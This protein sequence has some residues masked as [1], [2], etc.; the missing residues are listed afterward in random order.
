MKTGLTLTEVDERIAAVRENLEELVEQSTADSSAGNDD[1]NAGRIS[2]TGAG[3]RKTARTERNLAAGIDPGFDQRPLGFARQSRPIF[4]RRQTL[5]LGEILDGVGVEERIERFGRPGDGRDAVAPS[6]LANPAAALRRRAPDATASRN[7]TLPQPD[8]RMRSPLRGRDRQARRPRD[9]TGLAQSRHQ[10]SG[11]KRT[12]SRSAEE[13]IARSAG[14]LRPNRA[15]PGF[16]RADLDNPAHHRQRPGV[17]TTQS[18]RD[19]HWR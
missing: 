17:Q 15:R 1:L 18:A 6:P 4:I 8:Y 13:S 2:R 9:P 5:R 3:A 16:R 12:I 11:Q 19:R 10:V 7:A 14:G